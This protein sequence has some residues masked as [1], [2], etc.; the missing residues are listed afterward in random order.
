MLEALLKQQAVP[1]SLAD[2]NI[3]ESVKKLD[4]RK[5]STDSLTHPF[6][7]EETT[8]PYSNE[9]EEG[10]A[11]LIDRSNFETGMVQV[12]SLHVCVRMF[13]VCIC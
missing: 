13:L 3:N 6:T 4:E 12:C 11:K 8:L 10:F 2:T 7:H 1:F 9:A 5:F